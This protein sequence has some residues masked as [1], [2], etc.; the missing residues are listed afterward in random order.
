MNKKLIYILIVLIVIALIALFIGL[1]LKNKSETK[2][3]L[4]EINKEQK[5]EKDT[6]GIYSEVKQ[7]KL[8]NEVIGGVDII[9]NS[10][11]LTV[12]NR[13]II[14]DSNYNISNITL[15]NNN[16]KSVIFR[17]DSLFV[18]FDNF[19]GIYLK[20]GKLFQKSNTSEVISEKSYFTAFDIKDDKIFIADAMEKEIHVF[21]MNAEKLY[22]FKGMSERENISEFVIP[23]P[24]FHLQFD[25]EK[26]LWI[27]NP[28]IHKL[29]NYSE[30]GELKKSWGVS[31]MQIHGFSGCC[32]P[33]YFSIFKNGNFLTSEKS[34]VRV[35]VYDAEGNFLF[36]VA[37]AK[38][39]NIKKKAPKPAIDDKGNIYLLDFE[40][41][42]L[43]IFKAVN[44]E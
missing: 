38:Q 5:I 32:N 10:I 43:R 14:I 36:T 34:N 19:F 12:D 13:L 44:N 33:A 27:I 11:Y 39:L 22:S 31:S 6:T 18:L 4:S 30:I 29:Q 40:N 8:K 17:N 37:D 3:D 24:F 28:G 2:T 26:E 7:I 15:F 35:K 42:M 23:S 41:K 20:N 21:N 1:F 25:S 9:D 16:P